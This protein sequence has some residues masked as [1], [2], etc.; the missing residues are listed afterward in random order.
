MMGD[1][2]WQEGAPLPSLLADPPRQLLSYEGP[3]SGTQLLHQLYD[4]GILLH[5]EMVINL[6]SLKGAIDQVKDLGCLLR[7]RLQNGSMWMNC[8]A[9]FHTMLPPL[10]EYPDRLC[11]LP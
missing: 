8:Q 7:Q 3:S 10:Y 9:C 4:A 1:G 6:Q 5:T 2:F 11:R